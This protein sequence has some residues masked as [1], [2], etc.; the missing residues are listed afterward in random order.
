MLNT[1]IYVFLLPK[2]ICTKKI[3]PVLVVRSIVLPSILRCIVLDRDYFRSSAIR[4][5]GIVNEKAVPTDHPAF[6]LLMS[7]IV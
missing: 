3:I 1:I 2:A 6:T 7:S 4:A 5:I